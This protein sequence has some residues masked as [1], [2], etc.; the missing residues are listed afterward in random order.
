MTHN[1]KGEYGHRQH[2]M[3]SKILHGMVSKN[4]YVFYHTQGGFGTANKEEK[5]LL[6]SLIHQYSKCQ[7]LYQQILVW[8]LLTQ[9]HLQL[10]QKYRMG[11]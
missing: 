7:I 2:A 10:K 6:E 5:K 9:R 11:E 4:L 3:I 8:H 1:I